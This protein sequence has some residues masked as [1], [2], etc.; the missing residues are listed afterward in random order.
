M[1]QKMFFKQNIITFALY[2]FI[3]LVVIKLMHEPTQATLVWPGVGIGIVAALV[4]GYRIIPGLYLAQLGIGYFL[5]YSTNE[6]YTLLN[7]IASNA[8]SVAGLLRCFFGAFLIRYFVGY[9]NSLISSKPILKFFLIVAPLASLA[10]A[11]VYILVKSLL[12][13]TETTSYSNNIFDWWI[14]DLLG[15][16]IFAPFT[17]IFICQP[18]SIWRPRYLTVGLPIILIFTAVILLYNKTQI[19][20]SQKVLDDLNLKNE[21][22]VANLN[23]NSIWVNNFLKNIFLYYLPTDDTNTQLNS[24]LNSLSDSDD[25]INAIIWNMGSENNYIKV[26]KDYSLHKF[27]KLKEFNFNNLISQDELNKQLFYPTIYIDRLEEFVN[28]FE[29][30]QHKHKLKIIVVRNFSQLDKLLSKLGLN[31]AKIS[32]NLTQSNKPNK[33]VVLYSSSQSLPENI[34]TINSKLNFYDK[35]WTL[36][37]SPSAQYFHENRSKYSYVIAKIGLLVVGLIGIMLLI[38]TGKTALTDI[39]VKERTLELDTQ[40]TDLRNKKKQYRKL[41]EQHPVILWRLNIDNNKMSYISKKVEKLYGYSLSR[42]LNEGN[43]WLNL[44]HPEDVKAVKSKINQSLR[45]SSTTFELEYRLVTADGSIAWIKDTI[46]INK[47]ADL[48][49]GSRMQLLGLMID[50]SETHKAKQEQNISESKYRILFK[51]AVDPLMILDLDNSTIIDPNDKAISLFGLNNISGHVT[52]VDFSPIKQPDGSNSQKRLRKI[53]RKL[54]QNKYINF[55]W[56]MLNKKHHEIICNIDLVKLPTQNNNIVLVNIHDIT[57]IK[58]HAKKINQLAY[59]DNLTKLP[60]R[61]YFYSKFKYFHNLAV[62]KQMFGT[63]IYLDLDRFKILNDSLGHRAGDELLKMVAQRISHI[64]KVSDFCARLGGDEFIILAKKLKSSI[65]LALESSFVKSELI[66]EALNRPYQLEDYEHLITP[67]IGISVFPT[68]NASIDQIIHQADIAMYASKEK[69]KNTI[70]IYHETMVKMVGERLILEKAIRQ[71]FDQDEFELYYQP[72]ININNEAHSVEA[73]LRW[74]RSLEFRITT[75]ELIDTIEQIGLTHELG[76]WVFDQTCTQLEQWAKQNC[77]VKSIAINVSAKQFHQKLFT[78]Q[79]IS[80]IQSYNLKPSQIII[81]LT[82][83]VLIEDIASIITK[84]TT[85]KAYGVRISLD[86][87]GTGYSSLAYLK[88]LPIDQL[89]IDKMFIHDIASD[90]S[91][92]HIVQTIIDLARSMNVEFIAEGVE[93]EE[94]FNILK[95]LGC[96]HFQ[97]F[98]FS[99]PVPAHEI[100]CTKNKQELI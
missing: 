72:Q 10:S 74:R 54:D 36:S 23:Q 77:A 62:E 92:Q 57:E 73:L 93:I 30:N 78:D 48:A 6:T 51:H 83:A 68:D 1:N 35:N 4:W 90:K 39:Q 21:V 50:V 80:V 88:Q 15:F 89:K 67:S 9:P 2:F 70:T 64:T 33:E 81:E 97:G 25:N 32:L 37:L 28:V 79:V 58:L 71:A 84:L 45:D 20:N 46:N 18:K 53:F 22:I 29:F 26:S 49:T 91:S 44:I 61:E 31:H 75:E 94:Q 96:E 24:F 3:T 85:L 55:E 27:A 38:I 56:V 34:M 7:F 52:L 47:V 13:F 11:A 12:G 99:K 41:I 16:I 86:D 69:G 17:M 65:G 87:F 98:Y 100:N 95:Q 14:G 82:E 76:H 66:L 59:Y 8:F 63:I 19:N 60:N 42:W 40:S 43:F 5:Y